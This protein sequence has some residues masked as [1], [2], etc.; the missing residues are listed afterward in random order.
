MVN[1]KIYHFRR[2]SL[3]PAVGALLTESQPMSTG[4]VHSF[5]SLV[6][7][8]C[9]QIYLRNYYASDT[10]L[11]WIIVSSY[12]NR[13]REKRHRCPQEHTFKLRNQGISLKNK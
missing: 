6:L 4:L 1:G 3:S 5:H 11:D 10:F 7:S 8:L 2:L 9:Q 13:S 12:P